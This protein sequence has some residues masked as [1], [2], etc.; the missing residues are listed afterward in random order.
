M[1]AEMY[2]GSA[3]SFKAIVEQHVVTIESMQAFR[4]IFNDLLGLNVDFDKLPKMK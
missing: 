3:I 4:P 2:G 1:N